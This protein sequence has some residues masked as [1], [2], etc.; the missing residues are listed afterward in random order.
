MLIGASECITTLLYILVTLVAVTHTGCYQRQLCCLGRNLT[1]I[2]VE[3]EIN[4]PPM[5]IR[6]QRSQKGQKDRWFPTVYDRKMNRIGKLVLRDLIALDG[7]GLEALSNHEFEGYLNSQKEQLQLEELPSNTMVA[8]PVHNQLIFGEPFYSSEQQQEKT[9][10]YQRHRLIR[11][12]LLNRYIPLVVK[13]SLGN[14][15]PNTASRFA[16]LKNTAYDNFCY[17]D[18]KC[19]TSGDCCSDYAIT[20]PRVFL[21]SKTTDCTVSEWSIWSHCVPDQGNCKIGIRTR[22]RNIERKP[23]HGGMEC[24]S[25]VEKM[26]CFKECAQQKRRHQPEI[27]PVALILDYSYNKTREGFSRDHNHQEAFDKGKELYYYCAIYELGWV[28]SNCIDKTVIL[29]LRT[30]SSICVECQPEAQLHHNIAASFTRIRNIFRD[31]TRDEN[32]ANLL[33]SADYFHY[34]CTSDLNNGESG[35]WKLIGPKSCNGIWK[36]LKGGSEL[37][38]RFSTVTLRKVAIKTFKKSGLS[39]VKLKSTC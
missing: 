35:F 21:L 29:K 16:F 1:C 24:P 14:T 23:K 34:R 18:E 39:C 13:D 2:A 33:S 37:L 17:C 15:W 26:S 4:H 25:L 27:A 8:S 3:D 20:C 19:V 7:V 5:K 28:N 32:S 9:D 38:F 10:Y 31:A 36:R 30:G 22:K 6:R 12:S 11:Y